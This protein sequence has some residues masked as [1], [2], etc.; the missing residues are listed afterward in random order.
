MPDTTITHLHVAPA[1]GLIAGRP[2]R[3]IVDLSDPAAEQELGEPRR[4]G[5]DR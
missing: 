1:Q 3:I 2:R 5:S 4:G